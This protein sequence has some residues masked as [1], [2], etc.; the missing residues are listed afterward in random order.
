AAV[1]SVDKIICGCHLVGKSGL[2][3]NYEWTVDNVLDIASHFYIN[4]YIHV[5]TFTLFKC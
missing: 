5:D 2:Q 1:V 4:L 3:I